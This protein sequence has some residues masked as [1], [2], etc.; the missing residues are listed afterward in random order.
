MEGRIA[1]SWGEPNA[2]VVERR[3][4]DRRAR[5]GSSHTS[6]SSSSPPRLLSSSSP[7][8]SANALSGA[9]ARGLVLVRARPTSSSEPPNA[10]SAAWSS[11]SPC[12]LH[13]ARRRHGTARGVDPGR[14]I[15][16][17]RGRGEPGG[18][19]QPV[20]R[21]S[22]VD[23][24]AARPARDRPRSERL[25]S[26]KHSAGGQR[27]AGIGKYSI[28]AEKLRYPRVARKPCLITKIAS[29]VSIRGST[30]FPLALK[31]VGT[32]FGTPHA[33]ADRTLSLASSVST[34][35]SRRR[36]RPRPRRTRPRG[37]APLAPHVF[38][39]DATRA[40]DAARVRTRLITFRGRRA[41]PASTAIAPARASKALAARAGLSSSPAPTPRPRSASRPARLGARGST[42]G[43]RSSSRRTC[44][45][46]SAA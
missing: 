34:S 21:T 31:K 18:R 26:W 17:T 20:G 8:S 14:R 38:E 37:D 41:R 9:R 28:R 43:A 5:C 15:A 6:G 40:N 22:G 25:L 36:P 27:R 32:P 2:R 11:A 42:R 33:L 23:G 45:S 12:A 13:R 35:T 3:L 24:G 16:R 10:F 39:P 4:R 7:P 1:G 46:A 29:A 19:R 44:S 30:W